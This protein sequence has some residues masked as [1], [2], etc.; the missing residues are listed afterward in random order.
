MKL[1][2]PRMIIIFFLVL[3][4]L[5]C[6]DMVW[7]NPADKNADVDP[8]EWTPSNLQ[9]EVLTDSQIKITWEL[10]EKRIEGFRIERQA[11]GG[12]WVQVGEVAADVRQFTDTGLS[13]GSNYTYRVYATTATNESG[14]AESNTTTTSFPSPTNLTATAVNDAEISLTW[15]DNC[16]FEDGYRLERQED[17]G[18]WMQVS[19]VAEDVT[20]YTDSGLPYGPNYTYRV[21]AYTDINQSAFAT[22]NLI[23]T[24]F[25]AP[26][27]FIAT[28]Q[29]DTD[30]L[31]EWTDNCSFEEGFRIERRVN[32]G[33]WAQVSELS[34]STTQ[35]SDVVTNVYEADS[36]RIYA[37]TSSNQ[38]NYSYSGNVTILISDIDGNSY[39]TVKI[40][41]Q[42]WMA[43]NLKVTHY[44]NGD[45]IPKVT[46]ESS[47]SELLTGAY[48]NYGNDD[49]NA[50]TYGSLYNWYAVDDSRNIA[51][52]GW[53][54]PTDA[55]W[56]EL[57]MALGMSQSE[58]DNING[59]GTNEGSK[60]AGRADLWYGGNLETNA[61]FGTSGF[62]VLPS[63]SRSGSSGIFGSMGSFGFFW[64]A[65]VN[66]GDR[67]WARWLHYISSDIW[68]NDIGSGAGLAVRCLRD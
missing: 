10:D 24:S 43:E 49:S 53:H 30:I 67:G 41:D 20:V 39:M 28:A 55:E 1:I 68:R 63:G 36:Y 58:A 8:S 48:C 31:L 17:G 13:F 65:S 66:Y 51:P 2:Y 62:T 42:W 26:T 45:V 46:D 56:K 37:F 52:S 25:P 21:L 33:D 5:S 40:G 3:F 18:T 4:A 9:A 54:V 6:E 35:Y 50:D 7:D 32:G 60:L 59:R 44:R 14:F 15:Q 12:S 11:S 27:N 47:W 16:S 34:N 38:S 23:T 22:S 19:E 57:E 64:S 29:N 61:E